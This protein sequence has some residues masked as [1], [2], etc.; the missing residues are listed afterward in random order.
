[1]DPPLVRV[2][3]GHGSRA[4]VNH[5]EKVRR[6]VS[7]LFE[8]AECDDTSVKWGPATSEAPDFYH[9]AGAAYAYEAT[10]STT[11]VVLIGPRVIALLKYGEVVFTYVGDEVP[12]LYW[13][14]K[15]NVEG[16]SHLDS[17]ETDLT[18]LP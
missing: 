11:N 3:E 15:N 9:T 14:V 1:L 8:K 7:L 6:I 4:A 10:F 13:T 5:A 16:S 18:N 12:N 2:W 17:L